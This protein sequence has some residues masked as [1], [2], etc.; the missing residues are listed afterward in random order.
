MDSE[1]DHLLLLS[2]AKD[3]GGIVSL[4]HR[5]NDINIHFKSSRMDRNTLCVVH[6]S[7]F[8]ESAGDCIIA[9]QADKPLLHMYQYGKSEPI[10]HVHTQEIASCLASD[11]IGAFLM[12]GSR[13]GDIFVWELASGELLN[14]WQAHFKAVNK[15]I[16]SQDGQL[17]VSCGE[18]GLGRA[19]LLPHAL[20][21]QSPHYRTMQPYRSWNAHS[22]P[23][24]DMLLLDQPGFLRVY[25]CSADRHVVLYDLHSQ[26]SLLRLALPQACEAMALSPSFDQ[27]YIGTTGGSIYELDCN[28]AAAA[29]H[30]ASTHLLRGS[31]PLLPMPA[32]ASLPKGMSSFPSL[33]SHG[34]N[35][36]VAFQSVLISADASGKLCWW[37]AASKQCVR[38]V[39]AFSASA[40][41]NCLVRRVSSPA[42]RASA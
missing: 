38:E 17:L 20:D 24:S 6:K 18:D 39:A 1:I 19:W 23:V 29:L 21:A 37:D 31:Q 9:A 5:G 33:H 2:A 27:L 16:V 40:V 25:T 42:C 35:K 28:I 32:E 22:L 15:L 8:T 13:K 30:N 7:Q 10:L 36:L 41:T 11:T 3:P 4:D 14:T 26:R 34:I 12:C